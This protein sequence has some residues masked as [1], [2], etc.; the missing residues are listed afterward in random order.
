VKRYP[1]VSYEQILYKPRQAGARPD[2]EMANIVRANAKGG[3]E[4]RSHAGDQPG[5][6]P[7]RGCGATRTSRRS[8]TAPRP[9]AMGSYDEHVTVEEFFHVV[10]CHVLSAYDYMSRPK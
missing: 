2:S 8:S 9:P 10:K 1:E 3:L 4:R 6:A 5:P 7:T